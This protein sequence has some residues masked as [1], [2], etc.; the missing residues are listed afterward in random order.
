M[1]G[2]VHGHRQ[3]NVWQ[4]SVDLAVRIGEFADVLFERRRYALADQMTRAS[5]SVPSNIAEG[6]ARGST[7]DYRR[8]IRIALG[9]LAELDTLLEICARR[10]LLKPETHHC[11]LDQ[12]GQIAR[13]LGAL[14]AS[15]GRARRGSN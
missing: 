4:Q 5:I 13:Q 1:G 10:K 8:F 3:L 11:L 12:M 15:L 2:Q 9:S 7:A 14:W 6:S